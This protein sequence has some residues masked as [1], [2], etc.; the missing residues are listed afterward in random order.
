D[1]CELRNRL[2]GTTGRQLPPTL[3]FDH[4]TVAALAAYL[5][6][7][8]APREA[9]PRERLL[10]E[11]DVLEAKLLAADFDPADRSEVLRR[12]RALGTRWES[13]QEADQP[14]EVDGHIRSASANEIFAFIDQ[15]LGRGSETE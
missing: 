4:P 14:D 8:L 10:S 2:N 13:H 7:E 9:S 6:E 11:W 12:L 3:I 15:E 1:R 5:H